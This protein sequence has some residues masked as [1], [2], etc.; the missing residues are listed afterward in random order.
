MKGENEGAILLKSN[1]GNVGGPKLSAKNVRSGG[2]LKNGG[3]VSVL[4]DTIG[5]KC[6]GFDPHT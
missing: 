2:N 4:D 5:A 1:E 6:H 3:D